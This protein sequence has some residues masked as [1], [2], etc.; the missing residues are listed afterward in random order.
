VKF[1]V[2]SGCCYWLI[3]VIA[4][5][6]ICRHYE[7]SWCK[8][9][10]FLMF[11]WIIGNLFYPLPVT[12]LIL[13]VESQQWY[14]AW[15]KS[16][17]DKLTFTRLAWSQLSKY[18]WIINLLPYTKQLLVK[19]FPGRWSSQL[20]GWLLKILGDFGSFQAWLP[21]SFKLNKECSIVVLKEG[22][23]LHGSFLWIL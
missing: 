3:T 7:M 20:I 11:D 19:Y 18:M 6:Y 12:F 14:P 17:T 9:P 21:T 23:H 2:S 4:L 22:P 16:W 10:V 5:V 8:Y 15:K 1:V 13:L